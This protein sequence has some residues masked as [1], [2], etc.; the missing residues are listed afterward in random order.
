[1]SQHYDESSITVLKGLEPVRQRPGMYTRI[2]NPMHI[3]QE[4]IDNAVDEALGGFAN[5]IRVTL[6]GDNIVT[7]EDN[8]RGI[9]TGKHPIEKIPVVELVFTKLHAGGK[10]NKGKENSGYD[11]SGGLHGV[12]VS[13][14]NA[15]SKE[16]IVDSIRD[17]VC[18]RIIFENGK[19]KTPV[20]P[21]LENDNSSFY[22]NTHGTK[23]SVTPDIS[24]FDNGVIPVK[25]FKRYL[26]SKAVLVNNLT[27]EFIQYNTEQQIILEETFHYPN[28]VKD[29]LN[30]FLEKDEELVAEP[31]SLSCFL[32]DSQTT[33]NAGEG[34]DVSLCWT[35]SGRK[36]ESYV[37]TI[38]TPLG[39][40]HE[41]GLKQGLYDSIKKYI[42][43]HGLLPKNVSIISDDVWSNVKYVLS[44]K[45]LDPQF[46]GQTK[47]KLISREAL[48]LVSTIIEDMFD[49]Y[50]LSNSDNANLLCT[51]IVEKAANRQKSAFKPI[52]K[53]KT[54]SFSVLPGKL[55]DCESDNIE[56][57]EL[58]IVEGDSAGGSSKQARDKKTQ[59]ILPLKGKILNTWEYENIELYNE[60][61]EIANEEIKNLSLAI[62]LT[63]HSFTDIDTQDKIDNFDLSGLR[64]GKIIIES[65]ADNDGLHIQT[66]ALTLF[67]KHFPILLLTNRIFV[68]QPPLYRID[69]DKHNKLP[70][71]K[72][73]ALDENEKN[74]LV[75]QLIKKG[76]PEEKIKVSRFKGLG[77]MNP[78]QL[79]ETTMQ[80]E[81]RKLLSIE[82]NLGDMKEAIETFDMLMGKKF[83]SSRKA[84]MENNNVI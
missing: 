36:G 40:T 78:E 82:F 13:V 79:K 69:A 5:H 84:Y 7:V 83:S 23:V 75:K 37:N 66:L 55:T 57:N 9:P 67:L 61:G 27:I 47:D 71:K 45:I 74:V 42:E 34:V 64:Y 3:M 62:G 15:L 59:A 76:Y 54:N 51:F 53:K 60:K 65:D 44:V 22:Q 16:I 49:A 39:G 46:Q 70:N 68:A 81:T 43:T 77:E 80:V 25:D 50:L 32:D 19:V 28:G 52:E 1:M 11:F 29:Y 35:L 24:F 63:P 72:D 48:K 21:L 17:G 2:E 41:N 8:G 20:Y 4:V 10:F 73:Y 38:H 12:G 30:V 56:E 33:F 58:F 26:N 18:N 6:T 14:T 31:Y